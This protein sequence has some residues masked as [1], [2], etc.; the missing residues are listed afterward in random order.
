M[1]RPQYGQTIPD[2]IFGP[3][4]FVAAKETPLTDRPVKTTRTFEDLLAQ[5]ERRIV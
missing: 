4:P 1:V 2:D 5:I 3:N